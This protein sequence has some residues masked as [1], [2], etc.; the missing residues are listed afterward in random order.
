[1]EF[2]LRVSAVILN[3]LKKLYCWEFSFLI[4]NME[5]IRLEAGLFNFLEVVAIDFILN[6]PSFKRLEH[7]PR[8][9]P[10]EFNFSIDCLNL[11]MELFEDSTVFMLEPSSSYSSEVAKLV[12]EYLLDSLSS[13]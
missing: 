10:K 12:L 9:K 2:N 7:M 11:G 3:I 1:M 5:S 13:Q 8:F 6:K 4:E